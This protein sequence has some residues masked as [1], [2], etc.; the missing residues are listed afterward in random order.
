MAFV[1]D[2]VP[3]VSVPHSPWL[4]A[5][6]KPPEEH[7][8]AGPPPSPKQLGQKSGQA[9]SCLFEEK[10]LFFEHLKS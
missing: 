1:Q 7:G 2:D 10:Y 8:A 3:M 4:G 5:N 9:A 6:A